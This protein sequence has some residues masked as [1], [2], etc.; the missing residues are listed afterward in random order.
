MTTAE[1]IILLV[2]GVAIAHPIVMRLIMEA[3]QPVRLEMAELGRTLVNREDVPKRHKDTIAMIVRDAF[4]W[5]F[6]IGVFFVLPFYAFIRVIGRP[7]G[8]PFRDVESLEA[9]KMME[10]FVELFAISTAA[11]N[12]FFFVLVGVE[13]L[14]LFTFLRTF[15]MLNGNADTVRTAAQR[16]V[17]RAEQSMVRGHAS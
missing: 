11:A 5:K 3:V 16:V 4:A 17:L 10:R 1:W 2:A 13:F 15:R 12:P 7:L 14:V 8:D 6:M 9:R